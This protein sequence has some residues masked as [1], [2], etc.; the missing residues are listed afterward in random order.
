MMSVDAARA[1]GVPE[2][3]W[4]YWWGGAQGDEEAWYP[5]ERPDFASCPSLRDTAGAA[6]AR[7]GVGISEIDC[8]DF[9]SCFPVAVEMAC[10]MLGIDEG[11]PRG[12]TVTGGLPY[13]GGPGNSYT[14]HALAAMAERLRAEPGSKGLVTG[15]GW[16]LTK[17]S[18]CVW[19]AAPREGVEAEPAAPRTTDA[20]FRGPVEVADE[21]QGRGRLETY[22]VLFDREGA[23]HRGIAVGRMRDGRRFLANT[24]DDRDLLESFVAR[25]NVGREGRLSERGG[26]HIF[27][28]G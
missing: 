5:S 11:D 22:T 9:Y 6:L 4:V 7:A 28:P 21:V 14:L 12:F 10:E 1:L 15:N 26:R 17:H 18:A 20:G 27:D 24:P 16:Y 13:A 25:E 8:M 2:E 23:P 19:S 3:R